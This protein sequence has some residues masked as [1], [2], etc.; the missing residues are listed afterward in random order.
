MIEEQVRNPYDRIEVVIKGHTLSARPIEFIN[1]KAGMP[2]QAIK[3][4]TI[5][6]ENGH[7]V[8]FGIEEVVI[9]NDIAYLG[10][11]PNN[12]ES[13]QIN[14]KEIKKKEKKNREIARK[15]EIKEEKVK[16][17]IEECPFIDPIEAGVYNV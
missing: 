14:K 16:D 7:M 12:K 13:V 11:V 17:E 9:R 3:W 2:Y 8:Q 15:A 1:D 6:P 10:E 4:E 5:D